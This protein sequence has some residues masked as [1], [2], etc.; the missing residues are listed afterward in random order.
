MEGKILPPFPPLGKG[1]C[2]KIEMR[3]AKT[4][5]VDRGRGKCKPPKPG[6]RCL[7]GNRFPGFSG[8][9]PATSENLYKYKRMTVSAPGGYLPGGPRRDKR[10]F[11]RL[12][13]APSPGIPRPPIF[14]LP[15]LFHSFRGMK[16]DLMAFQNDKRLRNLG[17]GVRLE[18][19]I[20]I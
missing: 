19:G 13:F 3:G 8:A 7:A 2:E 20:W 17:M 6:G 4:F 5:L 15:E 16:G 14:P 10:L 1:S 12:A 11:W 9:I 18:L